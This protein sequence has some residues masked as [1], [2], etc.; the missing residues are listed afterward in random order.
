MFIVFKHLLKLFLIATYIAKLNAV[1][2][3]YNF[4]TEFDTQD[5]GV[6]ISNEMPKDHKILPY[7]GN[8]H[9]ASTVF[10]DSIYLNG[11][12]NGYEG[13]SHRARVPN[14]HNFEIV[15]P[16]GSFKDKQYALHLKNGKFIEI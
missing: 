3:T 12:Y 14:F 13:E 16:D 7:V 15:S 4:I 5:P 2:K 11:L 6:L 1:C 10:Y 9:L 8:G